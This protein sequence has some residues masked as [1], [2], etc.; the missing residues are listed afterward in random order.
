[1]HS[2]EWGCDNL[3]GFDQKADSIKAGRTDFST[4]NFHHEYLESLIFRNTAA[5]NTLR[6]DQCLTKLQWRVLHLIFLKYSADTDI[7]FIKE[8]FGKKVFAG[9][10]ML[11]L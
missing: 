5:Q 10:P 1:M 2:F 6:S 11:L 7:F 8:I 3:H 4:S 9:I